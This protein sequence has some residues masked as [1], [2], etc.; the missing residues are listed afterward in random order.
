MAGF[1]KTILFGHSIFKHFQLGI[2]S[3][4]YA[5]VQ[6][7][8][9]FSSRNDIIGSGWSCRLRDEGADIVPVATLHKDFIPTTVQQLHIFIKPP[10]R[11][12]G[13]EAAV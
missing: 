7:S 2:S 4:I 12:N 9:I 11:I 5:A 8:K 10:R 1:R 6:I 13:R 3:A